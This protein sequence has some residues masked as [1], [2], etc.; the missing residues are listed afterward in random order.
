MRMEIVRTP[1]QP[2]TT[3]RMPPH[4]LDHEFELSRSPVKWL[5]DHWFDTIE[6]L[7]G[8]RGLF[9]IL[10]GTLLFYAY[11]LYAIKAGRLKRETI[12]KAR[13]SR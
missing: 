2:T 11:V 12:A 8:W 9:F 5:V 4:F 10:V 7:G 6:V 3:Q 1:Q 13:K